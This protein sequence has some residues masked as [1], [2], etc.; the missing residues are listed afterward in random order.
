MIMFIDT[1]SFK[2]VQNA[3]KAFYAKDQALIRPRSECEASD[4][5]LV[6]LFLH[7]LDIWSF[8]PCG[9]CKEVLLQ[10]VRVIVCQF[11]K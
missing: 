6:F 1:R 11:A 3:R 10:A 4:Q 2:I 9:H 7:K 5:S 8:L